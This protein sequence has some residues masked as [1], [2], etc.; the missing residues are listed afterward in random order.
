EIAG[1]IVSTSSAILPLAVRRLGPVLPAIP[2]TGLGP[3]RDGPP[4]RPDLGRGD[5][6]LVLGASVRLDAG[7]DLRLR[8]S[9]RPPTPAGDFHQHDK[10]LT[11]GRAATDAA[12][13]NADAVE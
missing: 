4:D 9:G 5:L 13:E 10:R 8:A 2:V 3:V 6:L 12:K 11:R 7:D 1:P